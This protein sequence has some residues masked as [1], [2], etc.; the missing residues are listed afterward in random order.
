MLRNKYFERE[1]EWLK[2]SKKVDELQPYTHIPWRMRNGFEVKSDY[3]I[4]EALEKPVFA[5]WEVWVTLSES[6]MR[7]KDAEDL[8]KVIDI[9]GLSK[10]QFWRH[11]LDI[12]TIRRYN[13]RYIQCINALYKRHHYPISQPFSIHSITESQYK[14]LGH[15]QKYFDRYDYPGDNWK[16]AYKEYRLNWSF[17]RYELIF[18]IKK[19]YNTYIAHLYGD[20]IGEYEKLHRWLYHNNQ[21]H[22]YANI[23]GEVGRYRDDRR[24][25]IKC[26]WR[27]AT[28]KLLKFANTDL[29]HSEEW[30]DVEVNTIT[31]L[32][33][34]KH[35]A[36]GYD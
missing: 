11:Q 16:P 29:L 10:P 23:Y 27:N 12:K 36:F 6:R 15:L 22:A 26:N 5:G 31:Q 2:V 32:K 17:P 9:I 1:K 20:K 35:K 8:L 34:Y 18:K 30:D 24:R 25:S 21:I 33:V 7:S 3:I 28:K 4:W 14:S 19:S 13:H